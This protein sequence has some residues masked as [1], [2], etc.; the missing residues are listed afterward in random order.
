MLLP[1]LFDITTNA[2]LLCDREP[3][4]AAATTTTTSTTSS[5]TSSTSITATTA[6]TATSTTTATARS[7]ARSTAKA[8]ATAKA[9]PTAKPTAPATLVSLR[10]PTFARE[11]IRNGEFLQSR[12]RG[13]RRNTPT[14]AAA[15]AT[16]I[17][18]ANAA[19][20]TN[21]ATTAT[22]TQQQQHIQDNRRSRRIR[23]SVLSQSRT[24]ESYSRGGSAN[25]ARQ[26]CFPAVF[27]AES[28][29]RYYAAPIANDSCCLNRTKEGSI[30]R[31]AN[32]DPSVSSRS[33]RSRIVNCTQR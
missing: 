4:S 28:V 19:A 5:T 29:E 8:T 1:T 9:K 15:A 12:P 2:C 21:A 13:K 33:R 10:Q 22:T 20:A 7:T 6:S 32:D 30:F 25:S 17:T 24:L 18:I 3:I 31:L 27:H 14:P 23:C 26:S 11:T 16:T